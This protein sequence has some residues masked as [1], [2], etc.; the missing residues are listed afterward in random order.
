MSRACLG[1]MIVFRYK[2]HLKNEAVFSQDAKTNKKEVEVWNG[3][4]HTNVPDPDGTG[5]E[6]GEGAP[7]DEATANPAR[8]AA[9]N[10]TEI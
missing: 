9:A 7:P 6:G 2:W 1:K 8:V 10:A 5:G 3:H 4:G